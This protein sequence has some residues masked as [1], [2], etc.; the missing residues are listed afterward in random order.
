MLDE[1]ATEGHRVATVLEAFEVVIKD[2]KAVGV[3]VAVVIVNII[4]SLADIPNF[5]K[6]HVTLEESLSSSNSFRSLH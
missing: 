5:I 6:E 4:V 1:A 2:T 3:V